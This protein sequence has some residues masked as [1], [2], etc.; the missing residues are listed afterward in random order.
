VLQ[1]EDDLTIQTI[2]A[3]AYAFISVH[4]QENDFTRLLNVLQCGVPVVVSNTEKNTEIL[5]DAALYAN[6]SSYEDIAD[7]MMLLFKD[8]DKRNDIIEKGILLVNNYHWYTS[9]QQLWETIIATI[10]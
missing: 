8:E 9:A 4:H 7:K 5:A 2:T 1:S 3:A 6:A 10:E